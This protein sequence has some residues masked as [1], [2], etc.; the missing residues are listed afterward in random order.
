MSTPTVFP[1]PIDRKQERNVE[2]DV[3]AASLLLF[4][5]DTAKQHAARCGVSDRWFRERVSRPAFRVKLAEQ[6]AA[7]LADAAAVAEA[8]ATRAV[9]VFLEAMSAED[10]KTRLLAGKMLIE[11]ATKLREQVTADLELSRV[12]LML[13]ELQEQLPAKGGALPAVD[14]DA[15]APPPAAVE[16]PPEPPA[17]GELTPDVRAR[18]EAIVEG[19]R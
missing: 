2:D 12:Q 16:C 4:P 13:E 15:H 8:N 19:V 14:G 10:A 11:T 18:L 3:F 6:R 17:P 1:E 5:G 7:T 9:N